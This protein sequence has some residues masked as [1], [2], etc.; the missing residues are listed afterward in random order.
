MLLLRAA[1]WSTSIGCTTSPTSWSGV[2]ASYSFLCEQRAA[3]CSNSMY[4]TY[5]YFTSTSFP[6]TPCC[7]SNLLR[8]CR[9][10]LNEHTS[11]RSEHMFRSRVQKSGAKKKWQT[12]NFFTVFGGGGWCSLRPCLALRSGLRKK[13]RTNFRDVILEKGLFNKIL[14]FVYLLLEVRSEI[15]KYFYCCQ[16]I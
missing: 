11:W 16:I 15:E 7:C 12:C 5:N 13:N 10:I 6:S 1:K 14:V 2:W 4:V 3:H 9:E 8:D